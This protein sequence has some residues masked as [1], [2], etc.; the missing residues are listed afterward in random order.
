MSDSEGSAVSGEIPSHTNLIEAL[1]NAVKQVF[2]S[3]LLENLTVK[4][5]R[6]AAEEE[7]ELGEDFF[8]HDPEW[9]AKS[10][11][12]IQEEAVSLQLLGSSLPFVDIFYV[13]GSSTCI[14]R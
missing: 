8:K 10:K 5:I 14:E 7:L 2:A 9:S 13:I 6:K 11:R 1:R 12:I 3:D 4:R